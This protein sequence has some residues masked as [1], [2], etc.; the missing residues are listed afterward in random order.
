MTSDIMKGKR[1]LVMGV[2]NDLD[3]LSP[4]DARGR[5]TEE[6]GV[7]VGTKVFDADA[8]IVALLKEK[9]ALW[10]QG[11][12]VHSYPHCWRC[13]KPVIFRATEQWFIQVDHER[14]RER[15]LE[16]VRNTQWVPHWGEIRISSMLEERPDWCISRQRS[17]GVPIPAF[18]CEQCDTVLLSADICRHVR[19]FFAENGAD[20]WFTTDIHD[21]LPAGTACPECGGGSFRKEND[22]FDVWFESGSSHRSVL[23]QSAHQ[24]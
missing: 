17:W 22:I 1:G 15:A 11:T 2:A 16:A 21:L 4:V 19:D 20:A 8:Q 24:L 9:G 18:Y 6:A 7:F 14:L 10:H 13:R 12:N 3:I 5:L 23:R